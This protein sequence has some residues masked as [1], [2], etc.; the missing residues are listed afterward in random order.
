M[1]TKSHPLFWNLIDLHDPDYLHCYKRTGRDIEIE[2]PERFQKAVEMHVAAWEKHIGETAHPA[3]I[4]GIREDLQHRIETT[5][6]INPELQNQL[7]KRIAPFYFQ[8]WIVEAGWL[9]ADSVPRHPSLT[10]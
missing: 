3:A 5:F 6:E 2:E 4:D 8:Q 1:G 10:S 7:K 9:S